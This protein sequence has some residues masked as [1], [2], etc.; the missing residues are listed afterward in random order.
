MRSKLIDRMC[1]CRLCGCT[2]GYAWSLMSESYEERVLVPH[3][4]LPMAV[5]VS[6]ACTSTHIFAEIL[7]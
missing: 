2:E 6:I 7:L 4:K 3:V 1:I 5:A